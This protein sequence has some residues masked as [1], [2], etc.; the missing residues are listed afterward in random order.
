MPA[1]S[2]ETLDMRLYIPLTTVCLLFAEPT[3]A[4]S[5]KDHD[6]CNSD[7]VGRV[8]AGC[9]QVIAPTPARRPTF[10]RPRTCAGASF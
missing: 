4:A 2:I 9:T 8:I 3:F 7:D 10:A 5:Q 6:D 1:R